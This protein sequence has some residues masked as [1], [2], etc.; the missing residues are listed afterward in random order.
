MRCTIV[1]P[2]YNEAN[3]LDR[4][5]FRNYLAKHPDIA[6]IFVN[7]GSTDKTGALLDEMRVELPS[8]VDV[9]NQRPNAG[10]A[11]AV[12]AGMLHALRNQGNSFIGFWD[13][14]L[15][16]PLEAI[17]DLLEMFVN[18]PEVE[19]VFGARVKLLGR[20][21]ERQAV[22]HYLGRAFATC[23]SFVLGL[24]VYDTQC[25]AKL[26][27]VT[28]VLAQVLRPPFRS[29]WIFDV[30]LMARF[31]QSYSAQGRN[32]NGLFHEFPLHCWRDVAGSKVRGRDFVKAAK[33]LLAIRNQYPL[34]RTSELTVQN[35]NRD[36]EA[37]EQRN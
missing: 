8:Q 33:E 35:P 13:A 4:G 7:D 2:C 19:I 17:D 20:K 1:V 9:L 21:I 22:R 16:T 25:G 29:R 24:P 23:A 14:D 11:E 6:F 18:K 37:A 30:E 15:A 12:R 31:L 27:R 5:R 26:F 34:K 36:V 3:R 28:P 32:V 10:K